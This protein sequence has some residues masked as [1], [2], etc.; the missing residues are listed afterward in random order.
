MSVTRPIM[1]DEPARGTVDYYR[2]RLSNSRDVSELHSR[3]LGLIRAALFGGEPVDQVARIEAVLAVT[4]EL[5]ATLL[6]EA[7]R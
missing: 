1:T 3:S 5:T 6:G 4:D 7:D 2:G